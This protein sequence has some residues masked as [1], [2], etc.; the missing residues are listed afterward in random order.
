MGSDY[1]QPDL[2]VPED[3]NRMTLEGPSSQLPITVGQV[4]ET[5]W[6]RMFANDELN[7]LIEQAL[8]RN[9]DLRKAAFRVLESRADCLWVWGRPVSQFVVEWVL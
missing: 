5:E 1:H 6:W 9:H 2:N 4:P 8:D 7:G 3:W